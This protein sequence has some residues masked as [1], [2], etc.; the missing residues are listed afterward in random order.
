MDVLSWS[1]HYRVFPGE[2][3]LGTGQVHGPPGP[4]WLRRP[5]FA[6]DLQRRLPA[7]RRGTHRRRRHALADLA[8]R[9]DLRASAGGRRA[10]CRFPMELATLPQVAEPTGFNFAEVKAEDTDQFQQLLRHLA[11]PSGAGTAPSPCSCGP[12]ARPGSSSTSSRPAD[13]SR[14]SPR[15]AFDVAGPVH[16]ASRALQLKA[17][18]VPAAEPGQRSS[19]AGRQ[20]TGSTEIFLCQATRGRHGR[21]GRTEFGADACGADRRPELITGIDH[22]NLAQPWQ[23]FDESRAVL[24]EHPLA[25]SAARL[26]RCPA[27]SAWCAARSC[28][29]PTVR[30]GWP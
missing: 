15:W 22:V 6:G 4:Q 1:R 26:P 18:P 13:W 25:R 7:G 30:S 29:P 24:R 23:H 11:L 17:S 8:C 10:G 20:G 2:G 19:A 27:R 3:A 14:P 12:K 9:T 28:G 16:A 21:P 5:G